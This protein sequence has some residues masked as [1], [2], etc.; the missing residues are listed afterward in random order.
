MRRIPLLPA[1]F[2]ASTT[3]FFGLCFGNELRAQAPATGNSGEQKPAQADAPQTAGSKPAA[4]KKTNRVWTNED[5]GQ[6]TGN[7][8]VVGDETRAAA[9]PKMAPKSGDEPSPAQTSGE[10]AKDAAWYRKRLAPLYAQVESLDRQI[11]K[12]KNF[13]GNNASS[14]GGIQYGG[15]YSMTPVGDQVKQL[16]AK[17]KTVQS[18]ID[19]LESDARHHGIGSGEL[20]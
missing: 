7:V 12:L 19:D 17:K 5:V 4:K 15:R 20:R 2:L 10:D 3:G 13:K 18:T 9:K 16:E 1:I 6:L 11:E 14:E 8:S